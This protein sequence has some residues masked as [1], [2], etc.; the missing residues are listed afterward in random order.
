MAGAI[1]WNVRASSPTLDAMSK[2]LTNAEVVEG[3]RLARETYLGALSRRTTVTAAQLEPLVF[4]DAELK[5][6]DAREYDS[7]ARLA[8]IW[9]RQHNARLHVLQQT[10]WHA[11]PHEVRQVS[12]DDSKL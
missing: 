6:L 3:L 2:T 12:E 5:A 4:I 8:F 10:Q 9:K 1:D 11:N 7:L